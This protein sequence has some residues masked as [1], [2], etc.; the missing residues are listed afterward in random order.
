M[1]FEA[2]S[3]FPL[4]W[5]ERG[6]LLNVRH[7]PSPNFGS[8]PTQYQGGENRV[9][10]VVVHS[11]S[12]PPGVYGG[13]CVQRFFEN[14]LDFSAHPYFETIRG[15][16]VSAHFFI[17]RTGVIW[18]HVGVFDR[19]WHAGK[20]CWMGRENCNDYSVGIE[21]EGLEGLHFE[22]AQYVALQSLIRSLCTILPIEYIVGH[23][24]IAPGR[25]ADPGCGFE[26]QRLRV[27]LQD[28]GLQYG[29]NA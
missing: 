15:L 18:Q 7:A 13:G 12:L 20:S 25:K 10:M 23:E 24:H 3:H 21:L 27:G 22:N 1:M 8:R 4:T 6:W 28:L 19:A 5:D 17:E 2:S 9:N 11:I 14:K 29:Q 16:E 26:W